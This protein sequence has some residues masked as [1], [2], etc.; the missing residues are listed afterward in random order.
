VL[1]LKPFTEFMYIQ[2]VCCY[3]HVTLVTVR[4]T[5]VESN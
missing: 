4:A 3:Q 5:L 1:N 2:A